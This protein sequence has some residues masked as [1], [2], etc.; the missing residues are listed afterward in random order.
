MLKRLSIGQKLHVAGQLP[1]MTLL[2]LAAIAGRA[3][4]DAPPAAPPQSPVPQSPIP[5]S[6]APQLSDLLDASGIAVTGYVDGTY[7]HLSTTGEFK[8]GVPSRVFDFHEDSFTVHQA[9]F[10]VASQPKEGFGGV[11]NVTAGTDADVIKSY[12]LTGGSDFDLTQ[13]FVQYAHGSLTVMGGKFVTLAGVEVIN[14]T[15]DTNFSRSILFGYAIPYTNTGVRA[16]YAIGDQFGVT[17]GINNGWDQITA[18]NNGKTGEFGLTWTPSK[19]FSAV[20]DAY[21]GKEP[22]DVATRLQNTER[23]LVDVILTWS[24]TDRATFIVN[25]DWARQQQAAADGAAARW[26]GIAAY[27]NYQLTERW[28][29][30]LRLETFDDRDGYRTGVDAPEPGVPAAHRGQTWSEATLTGGYAPSKHAEIRFEVRAD[31]SNVPDA[32]VAAGDPTPGSATLT[33]RAE[34]EALQALFKF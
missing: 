34:S 16:V 15:Q 23:D 30:S 17:L 13:A 25:Y 11:V 21:A 31:K 1:L 28:R 7:E 18:A 27:F 6:S 14:E 5:Q 2:A 3:A 32:F 4:A 8:S 20:M 9:A 22:V 12:P 24:A 29:T 19:A 26:D 33:G 10:T